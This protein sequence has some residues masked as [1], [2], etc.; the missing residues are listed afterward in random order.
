MSPSTFESTYRSEVAFDSTSSIPVFCF[1]IFPFHGPSFSYPSFYS[2]VIGWSGESWK[3]RAKF[4]DTLDD[5]ERDSSKEEIESHLGRDRL[6]NRIPLRLTTVPATRQTHRH[7]CSSCPRDRLK[8]AFSLS[9]AV[10]V[11]GCLWKERKKNLPACDWHFIHSTLDSTGLPAS[12]CRS[13]A[14]GSTSA[15]SAATSTLSTSR[16]SVCPA[17]SSTGTRPLNCKFCCIASRCCHVNYSTDA[18]MYNESLGS[19]RISVHE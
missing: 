18:A 19:P 9:L 6:A 7:T 12:T 3:K 17:T 1:A 11:V 14:S 13:R 16:V 5:R 15:P 2:P 4:S 10:A 8:L